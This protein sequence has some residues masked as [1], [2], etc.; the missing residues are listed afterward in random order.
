VTT[1]GLYGYPALMKAGLGNMLVPWARCLLWCRDYDAQMIAPHWTKIRLGPFLRGERDK[2]LYQRFFNHGG[3]IAGIRRTVLL[4][5]SRTVEDHEWQSGPR[6][7]ARGRTVVRFSGMEGTGALAG[8]HREVARELSRITKPKYQPAAI[9][10]RPFVGI[11]VRMGDFT[12]ASEAELTSGLHC[13]RIPLHWYV[14]TLLE[15]RKALGKSMEA[16]VFSDSAGGEIEPL[17]RIAGTWLSEGRAAITDML[18][19]SK[20]AVIVASGSAFSMWASY[21]GDVPALWHPG[22]NFSMRPAWGE[23]NKDTEWDRRRVIDDD[24]IRVIEQ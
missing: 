14:D 11:H 10:D 12:P 22:Q 1:P 7:Q 17:L 18:A 13:R 5:T 15:L 4:A 20:A 21:L 19:L 16:K 8:R 3:G 23:T 2:R 6:A 24:F 9:H